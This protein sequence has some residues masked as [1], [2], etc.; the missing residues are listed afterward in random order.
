MKTLDAGSALGAV[1]LVVST[2]ALLATHA[3]SVEDVSDA[4]PGSGTAGDLRIAELS[5]AATVLL[6]GGGRRV[7]DRRVLAVPAGPGGGRR[8]DRRL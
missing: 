4:S 6:A 1:A 2:A 8:F 5:T 3:P 7:R